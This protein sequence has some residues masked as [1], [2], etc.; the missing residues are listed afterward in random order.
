MASRTQ[1]V[2]GSDGLPAQLQSGDTVIS[3]TTVSYASTVTPDGDR[4]FNVFNIGTQTGNITIAAPSGTPVDGNQLTIRFAIDGTGG[5]TTTWNAI[6]AF[7]TDIT[8]A[9]IPTAASSKFE[10]K[11]V[12]N[13]TDSK[14]RAVAIARG[15]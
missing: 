7:G 4:P 1:L 14:W 13:A 12:Y 3:V 5:Y 10:I 8:T 11:F 2:I 9:L 6:Y 15:F